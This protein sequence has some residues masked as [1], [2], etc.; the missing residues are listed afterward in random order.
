MSEFLTTLTTLDDFET[1]PVETIA[2]TSNQISRAIHLSRQVES[3]QQWQTYLNALALLSFEKWLERRGSGFF[4]DQ[5]HCMIVKSQDTTTCHLE[6]N[7]FK[8][9]L[10]AT[11]SLPSDT[12]AFPSSVIDS[13]EFAAHF[14]VAISIHEEQEHAIVSG[15]L[16]HDQ[17][18][19]HQ[20][21]LLDEEGTYSLPLT[22][23]DD[24]LNQLLLFLRCA[25]VA[26]IPLPIRSIKLNPH[27]QLRQLLIQPIVT[28]GRWLQQQANDLTQEL[29]WV[30]MP[31]VGELRSSML[32]LSTAVPLPAEEFQGI[33][34]QLERSGLRLPPEARGG[35]RDVTI[36]GTPLRLYA[37]TWDQVSTGRNQASSVREWS[38]LVIL[39]SQ[40]DTQLPDG[41]KLQIGDL[42]DVLVERTL[43]RSLNHEY[44]FARAIG[45]LD[46]QFLIT[47]TLA[48]TSSLTLPPFAF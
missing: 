35:Y 24:D 12:I 34:T 10:V 45:T 22:W 14:Y 47:I 36:I 26:T 19:G 27:P 41:I 43:D 17:L 7:G 15:F 11:E 2:F 42:T 13:P 5:E 16:R 44:L 8:L 29:S 31:P 9:C 46:E 21:P 37:V 23:F 6:V 33:L 32:S 30:L 25:D 28:V 48:D 40:P 38:L 3:E 1:L 39:G 4:L 18:Q 20:Q